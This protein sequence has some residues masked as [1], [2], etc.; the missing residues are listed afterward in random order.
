MASI[1]WR[2]DYTC[3]IIVSKPKP[4][5]KGY[6]RVNKTITFPTSMTAKQRIKEAE[7]E[8][9]LFED[10]VK[11]GEYL[12]G[13]QIT[14]AN[15]VAIWMKE[16]AEKELAPSTLVKYKRRLKSRILPALGH[17]KLAGIQPSHITAFYNN[18]TETGVRMDVLYK[19]T[20]A[21]LEKLSQTRNTALSK[22]TG[23][24]RNVFARLKKG[25]SAVYDTVEK[26][27]TYF[28]AD[29][30]EM[31]VQQD[32]NKV[33]SSKTVRHH[34]TLLSGIFTFAME[35]NLIKD[36]PT[37]RVRLPS[38]TKAKSAKPKHY[39][40]KQVAVFLA[41]LEGEPIK[42]KM[43]LLIALDTGLRLSEVAGL[44]WSIVD[45]DEQV[46]DVVQQRQ[47]VP[48]YGIILC[49]PKTEKGERA[50]TLS[51]YAK[52]KLMEYKAYQE[53]MRLKYGSAWHESDI[54]ITHDDGVPLFP[55][56]PST[57]F[58]EFI[59]RKGL[60]HITFHGL[61][62][63]NAS[64]MIGGDVDIVTLSGRLGHA[65]KNVT[66]N[67]YTHMIE[68]REKMAANKIDQF[69]NSIGDES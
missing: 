30:K 41:A 67:I 66:L 8:A 54:I 43:A 38:I 57:W 20:D 34:H 58:G 19:A 63:T 31:F 55:N 48:E 14:F 27:C 15:F 17:M 68:S 10:E 7:K 5:G 16:Y 37:R 53:Q 21:L 1:E 12:D 44:T 40:D 47:Y 49:D 69:Y 50:I 35:W 3:R 13:E 60:P 23:I 51:L 2:G 56:R 11:S 36:N 4:F 24:G 65:D 39:D 25:G 62:H 26:L 6:D 46:V 61:R 52:E 18:L 32:T 42:Y 64:L 59:K 45:I 29:V 22:N 9:I 33:L 28:E